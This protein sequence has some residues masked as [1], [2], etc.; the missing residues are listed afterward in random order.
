[1]NQPCLTYFDP[2]CWLT[3]LIISGLKAAP[4]ITA[5]GAVVRITGDGV[6]LEFRCKAAVEREGVYTIKL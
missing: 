3:R 4:E 6:A 1:M 2:G 5:N